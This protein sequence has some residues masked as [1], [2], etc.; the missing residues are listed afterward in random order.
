MT[1]L[2]TGSV[3]DHSRAWEPLPATAATFAAVSGIDV[4]VR[5]ERRS[6]QAFADQPIAE[7]AARYDLII[8]DHPHVGQ[9][10]DD[11]ALLAIDEVAPARDLQALS[12]GSVGRSHDSYHVGGRQWAVAIDAACQV[13]ALRPDLLDR[14]PSTWEE[15]LALADDGGVLMPLKPVDAICSFT[16]IAANL[17]EPCA[18]AAAR[19]GEAVDP[20]ARFI[21]AA[22]GVAVLEL[23]GELAG[24]LP[25]Q[26]LSANP[27]EVL[28]Q[29]SRGEEHRYSPLLFG[30][31]NYARPGYREALVRF[32]DIPAPEGS[33][34][35]GAILGGAGLAVSARTAHPELAVRYALWVASSEVQR[36]I[37]VQHGGQPAHVAAWEDDRANVA[38]SEFFRATRRTMDLSW[39]RPRHGGFIGFQT[40]AGDL[41]HAYLR[42][43]GRPAQVI[44]R[45][46]Q[47][48][49]EH[50]PGRRDG[51]PT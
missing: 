46:N 17:G 9:V 25:P 11:G 45:I 14:A 38:C 30:Y 34:P 5:W 36:G 6:L 23:M 47:A 40:R 4:E 2:L 24:H 19:D 7:L 3:W 10:A 48:Y 18:S 29:L 41:V 31:T 21:P 26:C 16:S 12:S 27:I 44:D 13:A 33:P 8:L 39:L 50:A 35:R 15:V 28:E 43:G 1:T 51:V 49:A 37:Y 20:D 42:D 22:H 32:A